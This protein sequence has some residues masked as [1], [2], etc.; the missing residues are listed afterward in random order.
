MAIRINNHE[1]LERLLDRMANEIVDASVYWRL[2]KQIQIAIETFPREASQARSFWSMSLQ[3][4]L[5]AT[6][7]RLCKIYDNYNGALSLKNLLET[8]DANK[9]Y[10]DERYFRER[11]KDNPNVDSLAA[12][13]RTPH[14]D[15]L[16]KDMQYASAETNR[17]VKLLKDARDNLYAHRSARDVITQVDLSVKY[18]LT[19]GEV[20]E[21][22]DRAHAIVNRYTYLYFSTTYSRQLVGEDDYR[23]VFEA[24]RWDLDRRDREIR[25]RELR[26]DLQKAWDTVE[27]RQ[28]VEFKPG[29]A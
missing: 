29:G 14:L 4:L 20:D 16:A 1:D 6:A 24:L 5:D 18:P 11:L 2:H 8:I 10:F 27:R 28:E 13:S 3:A 15:Q 19:K 25:R 7:F 23:N 26:A 17:L 9:K 22:L 21:L 12:E